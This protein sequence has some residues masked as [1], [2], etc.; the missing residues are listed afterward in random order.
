MQNQNSLERLKKQALVAQKAALKAQLK[1]KFYQDLVAIEEGTYCLQ[2]PVEPQPFDDDDEKSKM[3]KNLSEGIKKQKEVIEKYGVELITLSNNLNESTAEIKRLKKELSD[4]IENVETYDKI[5]EEEDRVNEEVKRR[6]VL[7]K[8]ACKNFSTF[9]FQNFDIN[10]DD[11]KGL[12]DAEND[13]EYDEA[14]SILY[15]K[16]KKKSKEY[17]DNLNELDNP[18]GKSIL[19][20]KKEEVEND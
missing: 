18:N 8:R 4:K 11:L 19:L 7:L 12:R 3:I 13:D 6:T 15:N 5:K 20:L 9:L 17:V 1:A 16:Q 10:T 14:V 2:N